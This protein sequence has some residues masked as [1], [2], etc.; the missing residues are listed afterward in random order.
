RSG[1]EEQGPKVLRV[2]GE[3][4]QEK[5]ASELLPELQNSALPSQRWPVTADGISVERIS[6]A[7]PSSSGPLATPSKLF[8]RFEGSQF[9][10]D[11][12]YSFSVLKFEGPFTQFRGSASG[13]VHN[14]GWTA[15]LLPSDAGL[16]LYANRHGR[17]V[18][19]TIDIPAM[20][21]FYV[22]NAALVDLDNDGWLDIVFST[23]RHGS[24]VIYNKE[25]RFT[26]E[27]LH[28]LPTQDEAMVT[29]AMAFG[30]V[31]RD[32]KLDIVLGNWLPPCRS[33]LWCDERPFN[34]YVLHNDG[35]GQFSPRPLPGVGGR[36]TL[37]LL[38]SDLNNDG[39]LDLVIGN[40]DRASDAFLF[41]KGDGTFRQITRSDGIIPHS[42]L[43]TM[44]VAS[45]DI[46]NNLQPAIYVGQ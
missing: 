31:D 42:G 21:D 9:G 5:S 45:A 29:G 41:G 1:V 8:T 36:Q 2:G 4:R 3:T 18:A 12:P 44:S 40:E 39:I 13:D 26:K 20:K 27:N 46:S 23:Y 33:W 38:L 19:Q 15:I 28:R 43:S 24:Y 7:A 16:S 37:S 10:L 34:N 35:N 14:D 17:F 22:V 11:G 30:D 32:G 25:G 6:F